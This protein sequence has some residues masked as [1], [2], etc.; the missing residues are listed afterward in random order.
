MKIFPLILIFVFLYRLLEKILLWIFNQ[1]TAGCSGYCILTSLYGLSALIRVTRQVS[2]KLNLS[3][4]SSDER[5]SVIV[6][7]AVL[8]LLAHFK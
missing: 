6:G 1:G 8:V 5:S 7:M 3:A 2:H 4:I